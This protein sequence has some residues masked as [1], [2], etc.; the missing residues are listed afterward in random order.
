MAFA[1]SGL[2]LVAQGGSLGAGTNKKKWFYCTNDAQAVVETDGYFDAISAEMETGD[3][4]EVSGD[5]D[6]TPFLY[7]YVTVVTTGDV[8]LT[9][10]IIA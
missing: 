1:A 3:C 7:S 2:V 5:T 9:G 8:A 10:A 6:G 4:I